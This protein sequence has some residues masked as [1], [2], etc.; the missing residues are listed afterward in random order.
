MA[1]LTTVKTYIDEASS[2]VTYVGKASVTASPSAPVWRISKIEVSGT[3][4]T[5]KFANS[6]YDFNQIW[7]NRASLTYN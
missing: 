6:S 3:V 4:T 5:V 2:T 7:D 1:T